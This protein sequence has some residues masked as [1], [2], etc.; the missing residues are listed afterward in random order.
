VDIEVMTGDVTGVSALADLPLPEPGAPDVLAVIPFRQVTE[1]G[2]AC[3]DD[4]EPII[5]LVAN[6]HARLTVAEA[7]P[8]SRTL[9]RKGW[10]DCRCGASLA[11]SGRTSTRSAG[12]SRP[13]RA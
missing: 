4:G 13:S 12:T 9:N 7:P 8:L 6:A 3:H 11:R 10:S 1:R 5:A 2:Y